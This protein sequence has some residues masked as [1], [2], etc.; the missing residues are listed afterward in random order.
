LFG[1]FLHHASLLHPSLF[2]SSVS[3]RSSSAL[4]T[5]FKNKIIFKQSTKEAHR[6]QASIDVFSIVRQSRETKENKLSPEVRRW[7]S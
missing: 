3:G 7:E 2:P 4:V 1:S 6:E 5:D